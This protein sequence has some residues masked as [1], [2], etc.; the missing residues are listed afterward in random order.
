M[1]IG[2][3][4]LCNYSMIFFNAYILFVFYLFHLCYEIHIL[5]MLSCFHNIVCSLIFASVC[6]SVK[7]FYKPNFITERYFDL[8]FNLN[9]GSI[10][11][12]VWENCVE[13]NLNDDTCASQPSGTPLNTPSTHSHTEKEKNWQDLHKA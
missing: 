9:D 8:R 10:H 4:K 13:L 12:G 3:N 7:T 1:Q 6:F 2:N 11:D 5:H